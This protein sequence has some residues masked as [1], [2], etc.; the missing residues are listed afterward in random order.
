MTFSLHSLDWLYILGLGSRRRANAWEKVRGRASEE[1]RSD[2]PRKAAAE[3]AATK[4][5]KQNRRSRLSRQAFARFSDREPLPRRPLATRFIFAFR[6][7]SNNRFLFFSFSTLPTRRKLL[8]PHWPLFHSS[9][10]SNIRLATM[11]DRGDTE[12]TL[13][14]GKLIET[15]SPLRIGP[16][17]SV[18]N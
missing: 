15:V 2:N 10:R 5:N 17:A 3:P 12:A 8:T 16:I 4:G 11:L 9:T 14:C 18:L 1:D 7:R 13:R 6:F